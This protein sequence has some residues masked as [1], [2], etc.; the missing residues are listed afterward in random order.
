[1][2]PKLDQ[3]LLWLFPKRT[4]L[5]K[6]MGYF[7]DMLNEVVQNKRDLLEN[8]QVN[9]N[10]LDEN[11]RDL[12]TLMIESEGKGEGKLTDAELKVNNNNSWSNE[13]VLSRNYCILLFL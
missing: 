12:L 11:E 7:L 9:N 6:K 1:V 5:H 13:V 3:E 8:G 2:F 4:M 10:N